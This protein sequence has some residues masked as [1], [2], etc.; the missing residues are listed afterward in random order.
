MSYPFR[1]AFQSLCRE[2]W[3]NILSICTVASSLLIITFTLF[4]LYN[5]ELFSNRLPERFSMMVS[6]KDALSEEETH[7]VLKALQ[8]RPEVAGATY[9]SKE[10]AL[11][12]L[13]QTLKDAPHV[14]EGLD[15]NPLASSVELKLKRDFVTAATAAR[16][17]EEIRKMPGVE[18]V[19]YGEKIAEAIH[20]LKRSVQ[21][22]SIII[23]LTVSLGVVFVTYSTVKI[24]FYRKREEIEII[25]LLGA[26]GGFVRMPFLIEGGILGLLGGSI[27]VI[28]AF[29]FYFA[30]TYRLSVVI[31]L[32]KTLVFPLEILFA[33][34]LV[35]IILGIIGS[36]IAIGRLRL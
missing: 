5:L 22:V 15:E 27:G 34:P 31:P 18:S 9:I 21:N 12:E 25:K 24:L 10:S 23:F 14:L 19:Y 2:K 29:L 26:T 11:N 16:I 13:K 36:A 20:A 4:F 6:M 28:G 30:L 32:L 17:S 35:G 33:L 8:K 3:I 7:Q 1:S